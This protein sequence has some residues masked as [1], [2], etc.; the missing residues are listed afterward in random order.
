MQMR[1]KL[2]RVGFG[3]SA[4]AV[5]ALAALAGVSA[6]SPAATLYWDV[7]GTAAG[8]GGAS[9][10]GT[11][12]VNTINWNTDSTGGASGTL[13]AWVNGSDAVFSAGNDASGSY[14]VS[15]NAPI[16]VGNLTVEDGTV[17]VAGQAVTLNGSTITTNANALTI[18]SNLIG[19]SGFSDA[20][21]ASL[22]L[23]GDDS[24]LSGNISLN[25][26][27][28]TQFLAANSAS[29]AAAWTI[30]GGSSLVVNDTNAGTGKTF[31]LGSLAG[32]GTLRNG[33]FTN[34]TN[35]F[36][37]GALNTSTVFSGTIIDAGGSIVTA[38]SKVGSGTL[39][40]TNAN[41]Y[42]G[43]TAVN[44][45]TLLLSGPTGTIKN[46]AVSIN[47]SN[48]L[49]GP[50]IGTLSI[51]NTG[52]GANNNDRLGDAIAL[53]FNG[54]KLVYRGADDTGIDSAETIGTVKLVSGN[55]TLT[56]LPG[57]ANNA[58]TLTAAGLTRTAGQGTALVN[59]T[60]LGAGAAAPG[61]AQLL[62]TTAPSFV[63][64]TTDGGT[65]SGTTTN[66]GI[67]PYL[68]GEVSAAPGGGGTATGIAN[69]F[70]TYNASTGV[71]PL[72]LTNEYVNN[73]ISAGQN[74]RITA[75]TTAS[76]GA[77]INSLVISGADLTIG[78]GVTLTD[79]SGALLFTSSNKITG[80]TSL[81]FGT[82]ATSG[83]AIID[84]NAGATATISTLITATSNSGSFGLVKSGDG[85]LILSNSGT[86]GYTGSDVIV[87]GTLSAATAG[88]LGNPGSGNTNGAIVFPV[89]STGR[90]ELT[91]TSFS[92][93]QKTI[94]LN[95]NGVIDVGTLGDSATDSAA[96]SGTGNFFK[97]GPGKLNLGAVTNTMTGAIFVAGGTLAIPT[98]NNNSFASSPRIVA[99]D[100]AAHNAAILDVTGVSGAGGFKIASGQILAGFGTVKGSAT[101]GTTVASGSTISGGDG[102]SV[103]GNLRLTGGDAV[104]VFATTW[105]GGGTYSWKLNYNNAGTPGGALNID[106]SRGANWD[107]LTMASLAV[108]ASS[109]TPFNIT[110]VPI[111]G[112][113][114]TA[115]D[116]TQSYQWAVANVPTSGAL[117]VNGSTTFDPTVF[118]LDVS[119]F[120]T[121]GANGTFSVAESTADT[122]FNDVV[123]NYAPAPEPGSLFLLGGLAGAM[124]LRRRRRPARR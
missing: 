116:S 42:T 124:G 47:A 57:S 88:N 65:A 22:L 41:T 56:I 99:G 71:R 98:T 63:G 109:G 69:T 31:S 21:A 66:L 73:S 1:E 119:R 26:T 13:S 100:S 76:T 29:A 62:F 68:V 14:T 120:A 52:P 16:S 48:S 67:I 43:A 84:V 121:L 93:S 122:G 60:N 8:S 5:L 51:D 4:R 27:A 11:W 58:A 78:T 83:E 123:I 101:V 6:V 81:V 30:N 77:S 35:T 44:A 64:S 36:E 95:G 59:G 25:T 12:D 24:W 53:T 7:N 89:G 110:L 34:G 9:P 111:N 54:G 104:N 61:I 82:G 10:A 18:T 38:V 80:G 97:T 33:G 74:T 112:A 3:K 23:G 115:F 106:S 19:T 55:S 50:V 86:N 92:T 107:Q 15:V 45:G 114:G 79:A 94:R 75:A 32:S 46:S 102:V 117:Q 96:V 90:L 113:A 91:G 118:H 108:S 49:A 39:N 40:L 2:R 37:I 103:P 70:V 72:D 105:T 85:T 17:T 87:A 28:T 20:G